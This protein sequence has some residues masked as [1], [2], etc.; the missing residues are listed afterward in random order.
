MRRPILLAALAAAV[1]FVP[2]LAAK[3]PAP[4]ANPAPAAAGKPID[5]VLCLDTS[6]SMDGLINAAK[7]KLWD[8]VNL[9]AKGKPAPTLR[10]ALYSYGNDSYDAQKG[11]VRKELDFTQDLDTVY[12]KLNGLVTNGGEEYVTLVASNA[13]DEQKWTE[14][15]GA[16][17]LLFVCGNEPADQYGKIPIKEVALKAVK[18]GVII[19]TIHCGGGPT[20]IEQSW[21]SLADLAEG[22][23]TNIADDGGAVAIDTPFDKEAIALGEEIN[24]TY[25]TYGGRG[26]EA[27][28]N[29][30][31]QD[32]NAQAQGQSAAA[33]RSNTKGGHLYCNND[34]DLVDRCKMDKN[35]DISKVPVEELNDEMKKMTVEQRVAHVKAMTEKREEISKKLATLEVKRQEYIKA[36]MK[37]LGKKT[38]GAFDHALK[39]VIV[40]QAAKQG[41][42][43]PKE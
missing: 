24:K 39:A 42:Q 15:K 25:L 28:A 7:L 22:K 3:D 27:L 13:L 30:A 10:V 38:E 32:K 17:K 2:L 11:Y 41:L 43:L 29:Q 36:E 9:L 26:R 23:Y 5:L 6:N 35:F 8:I 4:A 16:L 21:K 37:K 12:Q 19:N 31:A 20:T 14:E 40:D 1:C 34:W 18:K 33:S